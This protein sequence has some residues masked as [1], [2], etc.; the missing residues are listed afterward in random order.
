MQR[1]WKGK[2]SETQCNALSCLQ[3]NQFV[4]SQPTCS[5]VHSQLV[6]KLQLD[7]DPLVALIAKPIMK[8]VDSDHLF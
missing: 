8:A 4:A 6:S 1:V 7:T 2:L 3:A 5:T